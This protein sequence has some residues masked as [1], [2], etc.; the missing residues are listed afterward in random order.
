MAKTNAKVK[1]EMQEFMAAFQADEDL[2][3]TYSSDVDLP[4]DVPLIEDSY[5][6]KG[7][8]E[9]IQY[10][11]DELSAF[12][13]NV[14]L[15][16]DSGNTS[17]ESLMPKR[18]KELSGIKLQR[19]EVKV[20]SLLVLRELVELTPST[21]GFAHC[22]Y[23]AAKACGFPNWTSVPDA[24]RKLIEAVLE[25]HREKKHRFV[26]DTIIDSVERSKSW[27]SSTMI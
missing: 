24:K 4:D 20:N 9:E 19:K 8:E 15:E 25:Q 7:E 2:H 22:M 16:N 14:D 13:E 23:D 3:K 26:D 6:P 17:F 18:P 27:M 1:S 5:T 11:E 12:F 10:S 21:C